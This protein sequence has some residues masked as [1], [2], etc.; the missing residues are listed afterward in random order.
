MVRFDMCCY[1]WH[2]D[3]ALFTSEARLDEDKKIIR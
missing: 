3:I 1:I 2:I